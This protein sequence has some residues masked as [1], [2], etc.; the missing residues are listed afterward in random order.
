MQIVN[1]FNGEK[2]SL[3][4]ATII[5]VGT[6]KSN[7]SIY[8]E[9]VQADRPNIKTIMK[10][11]DVDAPGAL[12]HAVYSGRLFAEYFGQEQPIDHMK[13]EYP[14]IQSF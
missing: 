7:D 3:E 6:R 2:S 9:L 4:A 14:V 10:I 12:C 5:I 1:R 8:D 13:L 11:G